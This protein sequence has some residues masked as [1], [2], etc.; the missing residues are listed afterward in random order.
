MS[1]IPVTVLTGF[2]GSG[3][4]TLLNH[5]MNQK[6]PDENIVIIVNEFG[7]VGI[8]HEL[9]LSTEEKI[10]QMNNGC[11]CCILRDDLV[12]MFA[13]ILEAHQQQNLKIDRIIIETS[14]LAEPSP[15]AQSILRTPA[16]SE[17]F[18]L[19]SIITIVDAQN[20]LYQLRNFEES[21]EQVAYADRIYIS[22]VETIDSLQKQLVYDELRNVNP[23]VEIVDLDIDTVRFDD[24]VGQDLFDRTLSG[25]SRVEEDI[26]AMQAR[27]DHHHEHDHDHGHEHHH[28]SDVDAFSITIDR[29]LHYDKVNVWLNTL[30]MRYGMDLMRYKGILNVEGFDRQVVLQ[31]VNMAFMTD[32]GKE[33]KDA[34]QRY[35]KLVIIGKNLPQDAIRETLEAAVI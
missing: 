18:T 26:E 32:M 13:A 7:D 11:M 12:E 9:V 28:H 14:G 5:I 6:D 25:N 10:Y 31:G 22:K 35:S 24:V 33:W 8:D 2:L 4:T 27:H 16:L 19:D 15:I 30:I 29:P 23:F 3:K 17:H 1:Y 34:D 20:A 21:V